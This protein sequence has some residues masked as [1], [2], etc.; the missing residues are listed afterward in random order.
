MKKGDGQ[1]FGSH[2]S[3]LTTPSMKSNFDHFS[4]R[5]FK[6]ESKRE[7]S[8]QGAKRRACT[9]KR[10]Y[11]TQAWQSYWIASLRPEHHALQSFVRN[12]ATV[13]F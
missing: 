7:L 6:V 1:N 8:L 11:G 2:L 10:R 4:P 13:I 5:S 9:P 12:D 3:S